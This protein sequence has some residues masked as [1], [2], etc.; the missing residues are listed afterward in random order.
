MPLG[1]EYHNALG[2]PLRMFFL[3]I[4]VIPLWLVPLDVASSRLCDIQDET[5]HRPRLRL[6]VSLLRIVLPPCV[7][8]AI[9]FADIIVLQSSECRHEKR[10]LATLAAS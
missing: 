9:S 3:F 10:L 4:S 2:T 6:C 7:T 5:L 1:P 8:V